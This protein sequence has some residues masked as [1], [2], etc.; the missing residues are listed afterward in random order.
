MTTRSAGLGRHG[1]RGRHLGRCTSAAFAAACALG[2]VCLAAPCAE[3]AAGESAPAQAGQVSFTGVERVVAFADV[4][5][6]YEEL[7]K[8]LKDAGIVDAG[9][10]WSAG[11]SH[12]VSVGD[13]LDRG[14][15]SRKVMD[16]LMRL[17]GEALAVGGQVHVTLGNHEA[18]N[19]VGNVRDVAQGELE[20]YAADEPAGVREKMRAEWITRN[21]PDSGGKFDSRFPAGY[22]G[23]RAMLAPD[24]TYGRW[25]HALPVAIMINDT[26]FMH[27]G[28]SPVLARL[29]LPEINLRYRTALMDY[30]TS[31]APLEA[32]GLVLPEDDFGE[33][34]KLAE[35]RLA[36]RTY[37][38][39]AD[40]ARDTEAV[41][42]FVAADR[43][44]MIEADGPNWY[45]G[46]ALCNACSE[47]DVLK[48]ILAGLAA[49][50][51]V[52][53]HTVTHDAR[54]VSRFDGTVIKLDTGMNRAVYRGRPSA[55]ILEQGTARVVYA[56][57]PQASGAIAAEDLYLSSGTLAE[58]AVGSLLERGEVTVTAPRAPGVL[59]V[60]VAADGRRINAVFVATTAAAAQKELA[61]MKLDRLLGLGLVP[62]TVEREVQ[63]QR[64]VL[65]ARPAKW[66]TEAE[67]QARGQ[68]GIG[69]CA[70]PPQ[71][72]L[73]Y[74]F[75]ALIG[76]EGRSQDRLL[77]DASE[78]N[79]L[80]TG[81]DRAFGTK[82]EF[83]AHLQ[84]RAPQPG[85]EFRRRLT[86]LD[87][88][89]LNAALDGLVGKREI[90]ALLQRRDAVLAGAAAAA[91]TR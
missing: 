77:Y 66:T 22:F 73:M 45:R 4:H 69:W 74:G 82:R 52:I 14:A 75:D 80:L 85:P 47:T 53:G 70:L 83:P 10:H 90:K 63:G 72:E 68:R 38:T 3:A 35:Q 56:G 29:S 50:R 2:L 79:L 11:R 31:V 33:R 51:L 24:G 26:L 61:A 40:Q 32:A 89:S 88:A 20:A 44:P 48:P 13:L 30:L 5:G 39:P 65:Q 84:Q 25:L 55:L 46:A 28:P 36:A 12:L 15:D 86:A 42:R 23:H 76:N 41:R 59:D 9:L 27:G 34:V 21:G 54:V 78:W 60:A 6:A 18:M 17:Q 43:N 37:A 1:V 57:E 19:L 8:L 7:T 87:E 67:V 62:A 49:K 91:G 58:S 64:G 16:L 71:F 81:H